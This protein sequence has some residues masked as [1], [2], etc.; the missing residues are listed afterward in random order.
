[1]KN[2]YWPLTIRRCLHVWPFDYLW[3]KK[4]TSPMISL[5]NFNRGQKWSRATLNMNAVWFVDSVLGSTSIGPVFVFVQVTGSIMGSNG[6]IRITYWFS[7]VISRHQIA[8]SNRWFYIVHFLEGCLF[9]WKLRLNFIYIH[10]I[11]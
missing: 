3:F 6:G 7:L 10:Y 1:M 11:F 5:W 2:H 9:K 8:R 4:N